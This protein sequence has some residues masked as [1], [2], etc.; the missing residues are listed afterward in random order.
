MH[1]LNGLGIFSLWRIG[2]KRFALYPFLFLLY[3]ILIPLDRN[4][5][6]LDPSQALRPL[7][8][9]EISTAGLVF[10]LYLLVREWQYASYLVF[11]GFFYYFNFSSITR[12]I[13]DLL[14][15]FLWTMDEKIFLAVYTGLFGILLFKKVWARLGGRGN[16]V[17]FLNILVV[18]WLLKPVSGFL[19]GFLRETNQ[20]ELTPE[21]LFSA[22]TQTQ[23]DC[24]ETPDIYYIILDGYGRAD[25]L[26]DLYG[27]DNQPF[28]KFLQDK[29]FYIADESFTNYIQTIYSIPAGL[30]FNYI[31]TPAA[32]LSGQVY[33]SNLVRN[34]TIMGLLGECGYKTIAVESGFFFSDHPKVDI[35]LEESIG[36][37]E[38]EDLLLAGSPLDV[39]ADELKLEPPEYSYEGHRQRILFSF[40]QLETLYQLDEPKF[41]F[42]HI[43]SP[44]PPFV[45]DKSG[46]PI[47]PKHA[48][49]IGDGDDFQGT[50][51]D[52]LSGYREQVLFVNQRMEQVI[53][54]IL[55][56]SSSAP[57]IIIQ[58]DHG[59]GSRLVWDS[60]DQ[61]CLWER[62]PIFNAYYLGGREK[63]SLY[64][65]IS[66]VN[67]FRVI[68]NTLFGANLPLLPDDTYFT[69]HQLDRQAI[70][71]TA[72]RSS[73]ANCSTP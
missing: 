14:S 61:T 8:V 64:A 18:L 51:D 39:M 35:Y 52:Y 40:E 9:L 55:E 26:K 24:S 22:P 59:P 23:L 41:V 47:D 36:T 31:E 16:M 68:L 5:G 43:V 70:D 1:C 10:L 63:D 44:H 69:S 12:S 29:G 46:K 48:Y 56:N 3:V 4:M 45:F 50:F 62:T 53:E 21:I 2:L 38:F 32:G 34:N 37:T 27:F 20:I 72:K 28:L 11:M 73:R 57:I 71:I 60:P 67:S 6:Q 65:S 15:I 30:N 17:L 42:T 49:Y 19:L 7:L 58:G 25:M 54:S 66:P 13:Q 33:F